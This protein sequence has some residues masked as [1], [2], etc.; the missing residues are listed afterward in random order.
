MHH[1]FA[2]G[3]CSIKSWISS[4][5]LTGM[6][7]CLM[8]S[9]TTVSELGPKPWKFGLVFGFRTQKS[10]EGMMFNANFPQSLLKLS[11]S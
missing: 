9:A 8:L 4:I 3:I 5:Q 2:M 10:E 1:T 7:L 11:S 6:L